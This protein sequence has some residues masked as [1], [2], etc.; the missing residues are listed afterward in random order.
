MNGL[1]ALTDATRHTLALAMTT[2]GRAI[3]TMIAPELR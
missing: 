1:P 3:A 2:A